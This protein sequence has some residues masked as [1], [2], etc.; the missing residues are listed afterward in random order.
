MSAS[1]HQDKHN[2]SMK[3]MAACKTEHSKKRWRSGPVSR[4]LY[5]LRKPSFSG[6]HFSGT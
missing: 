4:I 2:S 3:P 6:G 5:R 1:I